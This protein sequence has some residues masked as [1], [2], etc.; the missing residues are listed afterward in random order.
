MPGKP[1]RS[2][3][4]AI[5]SARGRACRVPRRGRQQ[6]S[7][8]DRSSRSAD[9]RR[10]VR[11]DRVWHLAR[12][13]T[14]LVAAVALAASL[15]VACSS[16]GDD[17]SSATTVGRR[18][19]RPKPSSTRRR[20]RRPRSRPATTDRES[21]RPKPRRATPSPARSPSASSSSPMGPCRSRSSIRVSTATRR[22]RR[23]RSYDLRAWLPPAEAA[24]LAQ[25]QTFAIDAF[26]DLAPAD[27]DGGP[28]PLVVFSH[29]L[30]GYRLQSTFLTTHLASWGFVVAAVEHPYRNLT[31]VFGDLGATRRRDWDR[32]THPTSQQLIACDRPVQ[33]AADADAARS[34]VSTSRPTESARSDIPPAGSRCTARPPPTRASSPTSRSRHRSVARSRVTRRRRRR[35]CHRPTS[36]RC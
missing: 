21:R 20:A 4:I 15:L 19:R 3:S 33:A 16:S 11:R 32:P 22:A 28:Y 35:S 23:G 25:S 9:C 8:W 7:A 24:K 2:I 29:G 34:P 6:A 26:A 1:R 31:A 36:R 10:I 30:A 12:V 18:P 17:S 13:R 5:S 14:R 27:P